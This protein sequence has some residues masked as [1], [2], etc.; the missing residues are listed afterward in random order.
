[1]TAIRLTGRTATETAT[2]TPT[3]AIPPAAPTATLLQNA[4]CRRGASTDHD[5]VTNLPEGLIVPIVGRNPEGG[6]WQVQ[7]PGGQAMCWVAG[8]NVETAGNVN[9]VPVI[10]S[11]PL[12]CW[13]KPPQGPNKCVVPCPENAQP[14]GACT[15]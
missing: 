7:I 6:W 13:V 5:I 9:G 14:G 11:P 1:L 4:N 8:E 15:P 12:G 2:A 3:S 10:E